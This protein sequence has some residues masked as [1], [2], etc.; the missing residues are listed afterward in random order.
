VPASP[1]PFSPAPADL[2]DLFVSCGEHPLHTN[3]R[4]GVKKPTAGR[5]GINIGLRCR[6]RNTM[7][8]LYLEITPLDK[9]M[10][11]RL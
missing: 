2:K 8:G 10:P 4:R 3:F 9:K 6:G 1:L 7:R 11:Y 5:D